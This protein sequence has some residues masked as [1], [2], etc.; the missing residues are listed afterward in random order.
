M[1]ATGILLTLVLAAC[2]TG[3]ETVVSTTSPPDLVVVGTRGAFTFEETQAYGEFGPFIWGLVTTIGGVDDI[4]HGPAYEWVTWGPLWGGYQ[5]GTG[6]I[7]VYGV[8]DLS[9]VDPDAVAAVVPVGTTII[10][11]QVE[12]SRDQLEDY[13]D[14][15]WSEAPGNGVCSVGFGTTPNRVRVTATDALDLGDVPQGAVD[16]EW[17]DLC[18]GTMPAG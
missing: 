3:A 9:A 18:R 1:R 6:P 17:L 5:A 10:L 8:T 12:W 11:R 15:L 14:T 16:I 4:P 2:G 7:E 13:L